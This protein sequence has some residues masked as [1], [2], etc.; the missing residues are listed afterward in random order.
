MAH[1][2]TRQS[3][4]YREYRKLVIEE[5]QDQAKK[6]KKEIESLEKK[7]KILNKSKQIQEMMEEI[8]ENYTC[9][10]KLLSDTEVLKKIVRMI[11]WKM[12]LTA[13]HQV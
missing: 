3:T 8:E 7:R 2:T 4:A 9:L 11:R 5:K 1:L 13:V 6:L 12:N 10:E